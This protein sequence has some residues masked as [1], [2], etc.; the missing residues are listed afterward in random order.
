MCVCITCSAD[1]TL[2]S[3]RPISLITVPNIQRNRDAS[4]ATTPSETETAVAGLTGHDARCA[5]SRKSV[6]SESGP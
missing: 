5:T 4:N 1:C 3:S 6:G 2:D